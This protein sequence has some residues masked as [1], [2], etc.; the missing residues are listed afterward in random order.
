MEGVTVV[1]QAIQSE[2]I[3]HG[4]IFLSDA[5][6]AGSAGACRKTGIVLLK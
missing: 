1:M 4:L 6:N 5:G 3:R 2:I